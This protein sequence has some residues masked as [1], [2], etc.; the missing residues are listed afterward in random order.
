MTK[1]ELIEQLT[2]LSNQKPKPGFVMRDT[3]HTEVDKLLM[4]FINDEDIRRATA[5]SDNWYARS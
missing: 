3:R 1:E 5:L 2:N 4:Q